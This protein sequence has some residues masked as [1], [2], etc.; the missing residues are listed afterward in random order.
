M[1]AFEWTYAA[2]T[3]IGHGISNWGN[4]L[5]YFKLEQNSIIG[6][7]LKNTNLIGKKDQKKNSKNSY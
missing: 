5:E 3:S 4:S 7:I 6:R 1:K 2:L